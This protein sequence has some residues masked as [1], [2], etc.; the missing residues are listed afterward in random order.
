MVEIT[1]RMIFDELINDKNTSRVEHLKW[2]TKLQHALII[3]KM[4]LFVC[5]EANI[6]IILSL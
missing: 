2:M 3:N 4:I 6:V 1:F 5:V